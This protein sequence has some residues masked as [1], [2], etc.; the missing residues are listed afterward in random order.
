V[1]GPGLDVGATQPAGFGRWSVQAARERFLDVLRAIEGTIR[2]QGGHRLGDDEGDA[3]DGLALDDSTVDGEF[4]GQRLRRTTGAPYLE[5]AI[6]SD[7]S[8]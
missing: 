7:G 6:N 3:D 2:H 8:S 1:P 5:F 4:K